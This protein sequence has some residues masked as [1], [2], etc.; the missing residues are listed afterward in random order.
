MKKYEV[1]SLVDGYYV[2][3]SN[4]SVNG[5]RMSEHDA[6]LLCAT[7]NEN[8]RLKAEVELLKKVEYS[9]EVKVNIIDK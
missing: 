9:G 1:K 5:W 7:L 4:L 6:D 2:F 8:E 3:D